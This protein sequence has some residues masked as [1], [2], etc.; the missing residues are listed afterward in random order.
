MMAGHS[1][2]HE[3]LLFS[4]IYMY[5]KTII[6]T[7]DKAYWWGFLCLIWPENKTVLKSCWAVYK[8]KVTKKWSNFCLL[9]RYS[10]LFVIF[11]FFYHFN[12]YTC[13]LLLFNP[14][15]IFFSISN[16]LWSARL[17]KFNLSMYLKN[18]IWC[19]DI[20]IIKNLI[21]WNLFC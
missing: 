1:T 12:H 15:R 5:P 21:Q 10:S 14:S 13:H 3:M 19:V 20:I 8:V 7:I 18:T 16:C 11:D 6:T 2:W 9:F 17:R 4:R